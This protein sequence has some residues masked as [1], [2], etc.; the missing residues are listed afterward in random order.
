[1]PNFLALGIA[2]MLRLWIPLLLLFGFANSAVSADVTADAVNGAELSK[3]PPSE[4]KMDPVAIR[5]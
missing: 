5:A 4:E 3:R 2:T 1:M